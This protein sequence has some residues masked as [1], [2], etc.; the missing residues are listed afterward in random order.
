MP[1][2]RNLTEQARA[3]LPYWSAIWSS[4][5]NRTTTKVL[6]DGIHAIKDEYN[7]DAKG[8][9]VQGVNQL[10]GIASGIAATGRRL[11]SLPGTR[12]LSVLGIQRA[13]WARSVG[14][15]RSDPRYS[16][17]FNHTFRVGEDTFTS[18]RTIQFEGRLPQTVGELRDQI[19]QDVESLADDYN[20]EHIEATDLQIMS[21]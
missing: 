15:Q 9:T 16:I 7:P 11:E 13:P 4:A 12:P 6:W 2:S 5:V 8:P 1:P 20:V 19:D 10:R 17:Q 18:W 21:V 14:V 3:A